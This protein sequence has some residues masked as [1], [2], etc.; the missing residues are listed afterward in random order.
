[1]TLADTYDPGKVVNMMS[2]QGTQQ[3]MLSVRFV[4]MERTTAKD[5]RLNIQADAHESAIPRSR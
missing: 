3:V 5:L 4:E 1:M 2:V